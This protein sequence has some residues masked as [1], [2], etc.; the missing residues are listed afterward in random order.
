VTALIRRDLAV[1]HAAMSGAVPGGYE[2]AMAPYVLVE[3]ALKLL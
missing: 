1:V 2:P 3:V